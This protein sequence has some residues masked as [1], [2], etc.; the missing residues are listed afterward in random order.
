MLVDNNKEESLEEK[1]IDVSDVDALFA[2]ENL[3]EEFKTNAKSIFEAAVLAKVDEQKEKLQ[4]EFDLKLEE[5]TEEFAAGL[6]EKLDEY[7]NYVVSEWLETNQVSIQHNLKTEIAEGFMNGLKN[8][9]IENYIDLPDEKVDAVEQLTVKLDEIQAELN[10][11]ISTNA[12]LTEEL[13]VH[14][15]ND[16]IE[17]VSEG[18]SEIQTEKLKSLAENIEFISEEDYKQK[19]ILTKKKYFEQTKS[20]EKV[21]ESSLDSDAS[22]TLDESVSPAMA[23]YVQSIS[24]TLKK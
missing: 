15:M 20:E 16:L 24:R 7:L 13:N 17:T 22:T 6:V 4:E 21:E 5:Q 23:H 11:A 9:F 19:L 12:E 14:K 2:D 3:S 18:L 8:L 10:K 1:K